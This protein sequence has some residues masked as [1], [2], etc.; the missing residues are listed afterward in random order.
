MTCGDN[1]IR[2]CVP[3]EEIHSILSHCHDSPY[4]NHASINKIAAK[5][6]QVVFY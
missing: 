3:K 1:I 6:L 2:W 5:I 4:G